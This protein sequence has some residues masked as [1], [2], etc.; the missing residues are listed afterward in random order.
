LSVSQS[1]TL[2]DQYH[3]LLD[4]EDKQFDLSNVFQELL[5]PLGELLQHKTPSEI[6]LKCKEYTILCENALN[7]LY[8]LI[9]ENKLAFPNE[10][11]K[12]PIKD[13]IETAL[14]FISTYNVYLEGE[15]F[16]SSFPPDVML[17]PK[18]AGY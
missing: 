16:G 9:M 14:G 11:D 2:Q 6:R 1:K 12:E 7:R 3:K 13:Y 10:N 8:L 17:Y 18:K 15:T 4:D 5:C